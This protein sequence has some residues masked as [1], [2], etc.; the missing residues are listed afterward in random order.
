[1]RRAQ[2]VLL[3]LG[4]A[5]H[6][7]PGGHPL[8]HVLVRFLGLPLGLAH[9][10]LLPLVRLLVERHQEAVR[11]EVLLNDCRAVVLQKLP[12]EPHLLPLPRL[13]VEDAQEPV[14]PV[15]VL[16]DGRA[17]VLEQLLREPALLPLVRLLVER[18]QESVR[19]EVVLD[20]L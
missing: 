11:P 1:V 20:H 10:R 4:L 15:R 19:P 8:E 2:N 3:H 14:R 5:E 12:R 6:L 9:P 17:L 7:D 16:D 13:T 18:D